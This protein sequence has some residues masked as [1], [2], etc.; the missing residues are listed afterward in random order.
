MAT[1]VYRRD[2][3]ALESHRRPGGEIDGY[4]RSDGSAFSRSPAARKRKHTADRG[5]TLPTGPYDLDRGS[6][7][8]VRKAA[9]RARSQS[10]TAREAVEIGKP[11]LGVRR[12]RPPQVIARV[13]A[14][15]RPFS[16]PWRPSYPWISAS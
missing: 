11:D 15:S 8:Q 14:A 3:V 10:Q 16:C 9:R 5:R 7:S 4:S 6:A 2:Q 12:G 1:A 13:R